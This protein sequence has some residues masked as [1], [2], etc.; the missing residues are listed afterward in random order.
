MHSKVGH[1]E[2][3]VKASSRVRFAERDLSHTTLVDRGL[4][5]AREARSPSRVHTTWDVRRSAR[6]TEAFLESAASARR[7]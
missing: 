2:P 7:E 6:D 3:P 4:A 1:V 5:R